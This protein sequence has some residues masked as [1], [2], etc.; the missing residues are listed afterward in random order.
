VVLLFGCLV[1]CN[2]PGNHQSVKTKLKHKK[3]SYLF[4]LKAKKDHIDSLAIDTNKLIILVKLPN[5]DRLQLVKNGKFPDEVE[6]TYNLLK[7][8]GGNIVYILESPVSES[9][10]WDIVYESYFNQ[11]GQLFSFER[12]AGF[13]NEECT[14][15]SVKPDEPVHEKLIK[16]FDTHSRLIDS[17]Y[18]L[19]DNDKRPLNKSKCISNY[20][21]P[22]K[23]IFNLK[24][25]LKVNK[26]KSD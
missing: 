10:D 15:G 21:F 23:I 13:F 20:D 2:K 4:F 14:E 24:A 25:Y 22:Y 7:D 5:S 6:T 26:I 17:T 12:T 1:A 3:H 19:L 16:Y 11:A 8:D 18:S 9:G